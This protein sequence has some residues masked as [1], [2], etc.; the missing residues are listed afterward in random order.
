MSMFIKDI[1]K[2]LLQ[3]DVDAL[4]ALMLRADTPQQPVIRTGFRTETELW[5][6]KR[7]CP[8]I[9]RES[10]N[11]WAHLAKDVLAFHNN[12]G[13]AIVFGIDDNNYSFV[14]ATTR[15]DSKLLNDQLRRYIGDRFWI[16]YVR[17]FVQPDQRYLGIALVPPRGPA[18]EHFHVD[19][20]TINGE[21][22]FRAGQ[23]AVREGDSS[24][25]L[26]EAE[27]AEL[28]QR[29]FVPRIDKALAVDEPY[30]RILAPEYLQFVE[31]DK[32]CDYVERAMFN[33]R[34]ST[35]S[36]TGI[37][38]AGKTAL[39]TWAVLR[40]YYRKSFEFIVST[41][42]KDRELTSSG[43][44]AIDPQLTSFDTLLDSIF[45]VLGF[46]DYKSLPVEEKENKARSCLEIGKGL[47]YVDNLETVDDSRII[48]FTD[49]LP[50][51]TRAVVT[52]RRSR[53]RVSVIPVDLGPL[54]D[55]EC[56][57]FIE[58]LRTTLGL[59]YLQNLSRAERISIGRSCD[60]IPLAMRWTL[61]RSRSAT[62]ALNTA[63]GITRSGKTDE[64]LLEF[65]FRRVF[66]T[67]VPE[68]RAIVQ[69]LSLF[70]AL[71]R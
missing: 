20:P 2:A 18:L 23:A 1:E 69:I 3:R 45:D 34:A 36:I 58:S 8:R 16:D 17:A 24:K 64:E 67:M 43:I 65:S 55:D 70:I 5:E 35:T 19:A 33:A 6:Y 62:E 56:S 68:E 25:I 53:V 42:A 71:F 52:S 10:E 54:E 14:G 37:G 40:S 51:G 61:A 26:S 4:L 7:D 66:E 44:K 48:S 63:E 32:P 59:Q 27:A 39:A 57:K 9:G 38:G 28:S 50:L 30:F 41:T 13:G 31:R 49:N 12:R 46:P 11:A 21:R 60:G 47:L 22:L 15:L 29:L